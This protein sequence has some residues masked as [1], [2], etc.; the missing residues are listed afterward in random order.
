[1]KRILAATL[2]AL[3]LM[4]GA[5]LA[6]DYDFSVRA[7]E[8][9]NV[10]SE[11]S[12]DAPIVDTMDKDEECYYMYE[13]SVD[14]RGVAWYM[15][16]AGYEIGW[17]SSVYTEL[18]GDFHR[19]SGID[20]IHATGGDSNIR[21]V[22][23]TDAAIIGMLKKGSVA[24]YVY[25]YTDYRGVRWDFVEYEGKDGEGHDGWVSSKYT[26]TSSIDHSSN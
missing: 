21:A 11:P 3:M 10:R 6:K 20:L 25:S 7:T 14:S 1:M 15:V 18:V 22:P 2:A 8:Q 16:D 13:S 4:A 12:L 17:V 9:C 5:A 24:N 26:S 23:E 19:L